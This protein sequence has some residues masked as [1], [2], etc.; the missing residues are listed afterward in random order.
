M[1]LYLYAGHMKMIE[2]S[3]IGRAVHHQERALSGQDVTIV[4]NCRDCDV[5]HINTVFPC[6]LLESLRARA[7]GKKVVY[8][9]HSTMEDFRNSFPGSN[10]A[11]PFFKWWITR[12]YASGDVIITPTEY[13]KKLLMGYGI[14]KPIVNIS[15]GIDLGFF[16]RRPQDRQ[17]FRKKFGLKEDDKVV[18]SV[19]LYL[20]RKGICEFVELAKRMPEYKFL[21]FGYLDPH[22]TTS[23]VKKALETKLPNLSFP[24]YLSKEEMRQAY[25]GCDMFVSLSKEETEGIVVLEALAMKTPVL[26]RDIPVFDPWLVDGTHV[27]KAADLEG[28]EADIKNILEKKVPVLADAGYE[29]ARQREISRVG[30]RLYR[31]Y[32][33]VV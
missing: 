31:T 5:I 25:A 18:I 20:D 19:G 16:K 8:H 9:A 28:F 4:S 15:N 30:E 17:T 21:W 1:K 13:S 14:R 10:L 22:L 3:G 23:K 29:V 27:Y 24:G 2:K 7:M 33:R 12:C 6:D 26:V 32:Q 11:A